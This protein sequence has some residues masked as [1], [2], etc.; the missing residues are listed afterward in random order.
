MSY[1]SQTRG[2]KRSSL[3][4]QRQ[5]SSVCLCTW[6]RVPASGRQQQGNASPSLFT[7]FT[8]SS[9]MRVSEAIMCVFDIQTSLC[10]SSPASFPHSPASLAVPGG[11]CRLAGVCMRACA[12]WCCSFVS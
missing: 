9:C 11:G 7:D 8:S 3:E 10:A 12:V 5:H 4:H 1:C 2:N 6:T